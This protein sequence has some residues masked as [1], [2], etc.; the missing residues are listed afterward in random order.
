M[1]H[2]IAEKPDQ[3]MLDEARDV[4]GERMALGP[5]L[6]YVTYGEGIGKI[7]AQAAGS[8]AGHG[9]QHEQR[10]K[11]AELL[12]DGMTE[13]EAANRL[14]RL[15]KEIARHDRLYH[16]RDAPEISDAEYD[17]LVR[18]NAASWRR[19]F[20][21]SSAPIR[22]RS[23]VGAAPTSSA[24]QGRPCAAD[25]QPRQCVSATRR[26]ASSSAGCGASST[27]RASEPVALTAEPKI[28]GLSCSLRYEEGEL[29]LAATR[30]DGTVGEDVTANVADD[31]RHSA[32][33]CR[34]ARRARGARRGLYVEGRLRR[35][36]RAAGGGGR[37]DL[38]QPAQRRRGLASAEGRQRHRGA[39][40]AL[41]RPWLGR[42]QRAARRARSCRRWSG[43]TSFG[44]PVSDLLV[45]CRDG[46]RGARPLCARSS[47]R[48]PT[49]RSTSTAW[50]TRSTGSTGRSGSARSRARRAGRWPTNSPPRR[51]RRR[52]RRSTSRS[53][54][55]AS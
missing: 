6:I 20:R 32:A 48:A 40:A 51:P 42:G 24:R 7:E 10:G 41:P 31:R 13:A 46:R 22:R 39:A 44:F 27:C 30:G 26:C 47:R 45:R 55:P 49:C 29:V 33:I 35:P 1:A 36:Q 15:A 37:Q 8:Q 50:S 14:M 28:D 34:R 11:I 5:R 52:W 2:F 3:A 12:A 16:D 19:S 17:A 43:S 4:H 9:A 18:E 21:T 54:A 53:A 38:R 25:A 23:G